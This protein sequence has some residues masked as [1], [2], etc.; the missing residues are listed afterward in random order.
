M[1]FSRLADAPTVRALQLEWLQRELEPASEY[2]RRAFAEL[3]PLRR[4]EEAA[5]AAR[6]SR[7]AE[8]ARRL[9]GSHVDGLRA[10]LRGMPD[11]LQ[12]IAGAAIGGVLADAEFVEIQRLL[13]G[14]FRIESLLGDA[15]DLLPALG[16]GLR[17]LGGALECGR[18]RT[19]GFYLADDFDRSLAA[20]RS[21]A[22]EAQSEYD[23]VRERLVLRVAATLGR[24]DLP[25]DEFVVM[26]DDLRGPL[27][28]QIRV[29]REAP[30]YFLCELELDAATV[31]A[32]RARDAAAEDVASAE[33]AVRARLS[34][35]VR[36]RARDLEALA[37][38]IG[39][40]DVVVAQVRFSQRHA[41]VAAE[42]AA[43][44][45]V[46]FREAR[47][48]PLAAELEREGR[49][50]EPISVDLHDVAVLTGPN[51]GGK[52][53]ALRTCGFIATLAAFGIPVPAAS[54]RVGLFEEIAWLGIGGEREAGGLLSSFAEEVVR[55]RDI[56]ARSAPRM[57]VL[58][59]EFAR[60]TTPHEGKAL[61]I[62]LVGALRAR[63]RTALLATHLAG[64]AEATG[65]RHFGVRG[66]R[67][68]P[69][70][71]PRGDLQ[72]ALALL[73]ASMDYSIEEIAE[74]GE[75]PAD[76]IALARL[77]GLDDDLIAAARSAL[78]R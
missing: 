64:I 76:A 10:T 62:A 51:M 34:E 58:A 11:A 52:S 68:I 12:A 32:L 69:A 39:A 50:Y 72:A 61:V 66:M 23:A 56:L 41:C 22:A 21:R 27:S 54:A 47:F 8:L 36:A 1:R 3:S 48:L 46:A 16:G 44:P 42:I 60:T 73:A 24:E 77:L 4:G 40:I 18:T 13:D 75:R 59:D 28:A 7:V 30:T 17:S 65:A 6:S 15:G 26:R 9:D 49:S 71:P 35:L 53:I 20:A 45:V 70:A 14:A 43:E 37:G 55:L 29:V 33:E 63:G 38:S 67:G 19:G 25:G 31:E 78:E 5:A 74:G 2:G 57:L